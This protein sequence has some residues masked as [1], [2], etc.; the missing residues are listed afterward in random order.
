MRRKSRT[1]ILEQYK[2]TEGKE[3][4]EEG[5]SFKLLDIGFHTSPNST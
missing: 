2:P 5:E 3:K 4:E 1:T